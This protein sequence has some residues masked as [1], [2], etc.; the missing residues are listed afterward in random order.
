MYQQTSNK[1]TEKLRIVAG[2]FI[3]QNGTFGSSVF[4]I[5]LSDFFFICDKRAKY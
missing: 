2:T 5:T 4:V 1:T 3:F